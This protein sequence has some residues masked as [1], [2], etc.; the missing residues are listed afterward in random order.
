MKL[1]C[2]P[3]WSAA[4]RAGRWGRFVSETRRPGERSTAGAD[5]WVRVR[6]ERGRGAGVSRWAAARGEGER[7]T[8]GRRASRAEREPMG[9]AGH[10]KERGR[11]GLVWFPGPYFGFLFLILLL[12]YF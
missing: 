12:F 8:L 5:V 11:A 3:S 9:R 2:G 7:R 1:P 10:E 6:R 4:G